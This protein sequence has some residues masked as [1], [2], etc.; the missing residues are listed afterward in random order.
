LDSIEKNLQLGAFDRVL[1][2]IGNDIEVI[3]SKILALVKE[4]KDRELALALLG[5]ERNRLAANISS[6]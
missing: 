2:G 3:N 5:A 1:A 6:E 4:L